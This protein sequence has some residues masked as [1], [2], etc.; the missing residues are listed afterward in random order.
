MAKIAKVVSKD[1]DGNEKVVIVK[2]PNHKQLNDAHMYSSKIF[3]QAKNAGACLRD[4]LD[5]F[6]REQGIWTKGDDDKLN[7]IITSFN[8]NLEIVNTGKNKDGSKV[9]LSEARK[10]AIEVRRNRLA[11]NLILAKK[12]EHDAYT[13]EGQAENAKFDY[14]VSVCVVDEN[15]KLIFSNLDDYYEKQEEPYA[16]EAATKLSNLTYNLDPDW[17][18]KLPENEFLLKYKLVDDKLRYYTNKDGKRVNVENELIDELG[19][20]VDE[21]GKLIDIEEKQEHVEPEFENDL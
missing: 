20:K 21:N 12:R 8:D 11:M 10:A 7:E 3:N 4:K 19:R 6:M 2:K 17:E 9:K 13:I 1:N 5:E 14:L 15:D 16:I 18:K